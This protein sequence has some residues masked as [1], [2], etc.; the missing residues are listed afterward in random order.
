[1]AAIEIEGLRKSYR[2]RAV[3]DGVDLAVEQGEVFGV[4]GRNGAGKTTTVECAVGLRRPDGG[5]VRVFGADPRRER[6]RVRQAV[7]VQLQQTHLHPALTVIE[8][9]RMYRSFYPGG[10]DPDELVERLGLGGVRGT[11][12]E[13]LSGGEGQRLSIALALVGR[14]RLAVLDELTTGLDS[15]ARRGMWGLIEGMRDEGV[16][17]LLV[18]HFMEEAERLC[19]R[20][21]VF[22]AGRVLALDTPAGL[23]GRAGGGAEVS[24]RAHAP[25]ERSL[26]TALPGVEEVV[27][28]GGEVAVSG[29]GDLVGEVTAALLRHGVPATDFRTRT[30]TLDDAFL[31]LTGHE[32]EEPAA[33]GS[34]M[35]GR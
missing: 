31:A 4:L 25:L 2:G 29:G 5:R 6:D 8:L 21:A 16:T 22:D 3:V 7:G 15:S 19:D 30:A 34:A 10:L 33:D 18:T 20:I 26:L 13:G 24:F 9:V 11:R 27:V 1:M 32:P 35:K 28:R 17:V 12:Y 14:P 23:I